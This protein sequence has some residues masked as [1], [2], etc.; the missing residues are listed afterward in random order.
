[1][2][3]R[4]FRLPKSKTITVNDLLTE[5]E[6]NALL[7]DVIKEKANIE[8]IIVIQQDKDGR[9]AWKK[10]GFSFLEVIGILEQVKQWELEDDGYDD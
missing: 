7:N 8:G 6:V 2:K 1:M 4:V 9:I 5:N 3:Q 10:T